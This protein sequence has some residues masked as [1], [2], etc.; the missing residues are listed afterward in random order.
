[1]KR[2]KETDRIYHR[3]RYKYPDI[4]IHIF[5]DSIYVDEPQRIHI[6][7]LIVNDNGLVIEKN[8]KALPI[9]YEK[10]RILEFVDI[11]SVS[12]IVCTS[13]PF[14]HKPYRPWFLRPYMKISG[15]I[16]DT[17][18][19]EEVE[20]AFRN[21]PY[22]LRINRDEER[23]IEAIFK[24][25]KTGITITAFIIFNLGQLDIEKRLESCKLL[26]IPTVKDPI[27]NIEDIDYAWLD[28]LEL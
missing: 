16:R 8:G 9:H 4:K 21:V 25:D 6:S 26:G 2:S 28:K 15:I 19:D 17:V 12:R 14:D 10:A 22:S 3:L 1:M 7:D 18:K 24:S 27:T 13:E 20:I 11:Q 23:E 5:G